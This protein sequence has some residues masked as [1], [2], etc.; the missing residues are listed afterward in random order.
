VG[1]VRKFPAKTKNPTKLDYSAKQNNITKKVDKPIE[2]I[3]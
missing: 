3:V 1:V 2:L